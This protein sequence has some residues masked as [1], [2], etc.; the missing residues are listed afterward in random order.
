M[1]KIAI[2]MPAYNEEKRI[3]QTL[4]AY[5]DYF[6][7]LVNEKNLDYEILVVVNNTADDTVEIIK[8]HQKENK[9]IRYL[10][11]K[12]GGKGFA[13][14]EGFKNALKENND[15]IGFVDSDMATKP[16][17]Y[18]ELIKKIGNSDGIIAS[19]WIRGAVVMPKPFLSRKIARWAFNT[20]TRTFLFLPYRDTQCGAKIFKKEAIEKIIPNLSMSQWAFDVDLLYQIRKAGFRVKEVPT[21]WTDKEYSKIN[22]WKAGPGMA[23]GIIRLSL[24]NSPFKMFTRIYDKLLTSF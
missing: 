16:E 1:K 9:K 17:Y 19:R 22:F 4:K 12:P 18:F 23:L 11:L 20:L 7:R 3:G 8:M 24:L 15:L 2:I 10:N 13:I 6:N 14:I 5:S 21:I